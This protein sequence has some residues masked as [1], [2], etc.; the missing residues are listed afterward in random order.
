MCAMCT[1]EAMV[2]LGLTLGVTLGLL[3]EGTLITDA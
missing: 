3:A 2:T 1:G